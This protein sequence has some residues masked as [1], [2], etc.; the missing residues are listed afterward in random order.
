MTSI[1]SNGYTF[2]FDMRPGAFPV[3]WLGLVCPRWEQDLQQHMLAWL[4]QRLAG[5]TNHTVS[6]IAQ[7]LV[8]YD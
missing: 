2:A 8:K 1:S 7:V 6:V 5:R 3:P 4:D